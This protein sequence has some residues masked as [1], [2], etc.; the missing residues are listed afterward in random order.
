ME[1]WYR[2]AKL[3]TIFEGTREIQRMV[4]GRTLAAEA[5]KGPQHHQLPGDH[6]RLSRKCGHGSLA[7]ARAGDAFLKLA[8]E[9]P[10]KLVELGGKL[11]SPG[12]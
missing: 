8:Q 3:Y 6:G 9:A 5:V 7:R 11:A 12:K 2:D 10:G 4:I 1:K